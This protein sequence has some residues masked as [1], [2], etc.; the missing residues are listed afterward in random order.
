MVD[1]KPYV[2]PE[3][4]YYKIFIESDGSDINITTSDIE[5]AEIETSY[6]QFPSD[7]RVLDALFDIHSTEAD[8][9]TTRLR[10]IKLYTDGTQG[11]NIPPAGNFDYCTIY[12]LGYLEES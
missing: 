1:L 2:I 11:I 4:R 6:I 8:A 3:G 7:F 5:D 12:V 9:S 10:D